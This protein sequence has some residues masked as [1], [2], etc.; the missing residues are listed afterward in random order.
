[1]PTWLWLGEVDPEHRAK[2]VSY[3]YWIKIWQATP[4]WATREPVA[5]I[6]HEAAQRR[7]AGED[8]EVDH[9][10]PLASPLVCGLHWHANLRIIERLDNVEKSNHHWPDMPNDAQ[11]SFNFTDSENIEFYS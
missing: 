3:R 4:A 7:A 9:I 8:V 11:L 2:W 10:V 1:M 5:A 6:Y